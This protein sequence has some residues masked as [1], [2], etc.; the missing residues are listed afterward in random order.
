MLGRYFGSLIAVSAAACCQAQMYFDKGNAILVPETNRV[1]RG[2]AHTNLL[3]NLSNPILDQIANDRGIRPFVSVG[4][5]S[6][7]TVRKAYHLPSNG[8]AG[9]I[10]I[11]D[12]YNDPSALADFN[13]FSKQFGLPV[14][15][16][17]V[18]TASTNKVFQI[19]YATGSKP[20]DAPGAGP[21]WA[22]EESLDFEWAHAI[23]PNAKIVLV[24]GADDSSLDAAVNVAKTI[25]GVH[26][27]S[28]SWGSTESP[29]GNPSSQP[30]NQNG[31]VFFGATGDSPN[32]LNYP[33]LFPNVVAVGGTS[34]HVSNGDV[35]SET[36]WN[37]SGGGPSAIVARPQYQN[38]IQSIVQGFRGTPDISAIADPSTGVAVLSTY[39]DGGWTVYG[40]TSLSTPVC[41][42]IANVR[43]SY[44]NSSFDEN[45]RNYANL[46][47]SVFRDIT[48]GTDGVYTAG[49]GWDFITGC[50]SPLGLFSQSQALATSISVAHGKPWSGTLANLAAIDGATYVTAST[51]YSA[52]VGEVA[53]DYLIVHFGAASN[54]YSQIYLSVTAAT[55]L[56]ATTQVFAYDYSTRGYTPLGNYVTTATQGSKTFQFSPAQAANYFDASNNIH[57]YIASNT[58]NRNTVA[59]YLKLDQ[60][61]GNGLN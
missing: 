11:V 40:G 3:R 27:V 41:A 38:G 14:E 6:P 43:G 34:L 9:I 39:A 36:A 24:E 26:E 8:G 10:A 15:T 50:G 48:S 5:Y 52:S 60:V 28:L 37:S 44:S 61:V 57:L 55:T 20:I 25:T 19:V 33:A 47:K 35:S 45:T 31:V 46:G 53:A 59:F 17:S 54:S 13:N 4:G 23:A 49:A 29:S 51:P 7:D 30:Y 56:P 2:H 12:A 32:Q 16:S 1:S 22:S 58:P 18:V 42:A 21:N